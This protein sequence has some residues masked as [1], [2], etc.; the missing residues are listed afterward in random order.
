MAQT[1]LLEE[2]DRAHFMT[3]RFDRNGNDKLHMQSLTGIAAVDFR[4][5]GVNSYSQ[6]FTAAQQL[7]LGAETNTEIWRRMV[8]NIAATNN[9]DHAKNVSFLADQQGNW[10]LSPAYDL[11]FAYNPAGEW[12]NAHQM[13][14]NGK[15]RDI[16][17]DDIMAVADLFAVERTGAVLRSVRD[18]LGSW[19][20]FAGRAGVPAA[21]ADAIEQQF[22]IEVL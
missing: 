22:H 10:R 1:R 12:T 18:A 16:G 2:H 5:T 4:A 3:R 14:V 7:G 20:E 13:S 17:H 15:F 9:D 11:T 19:R 8:F 6:V 21:Q